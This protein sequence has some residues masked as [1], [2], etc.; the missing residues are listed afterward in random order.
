MS[1][2]V[3]YCLAR[4]LSSIAEFIFR[5]P[6]PTPALTKQ[7]FDLL[8]LAG[9]FSLPKMK[10]INFFKKFLF[11]KFLLYKE[12]QV[13]SKLFLAV[14]NCSLSIFRWKLDLLKSHTL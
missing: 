6:F 12:N 14:T 2:E 3:L 9:S 7:L 4:C 10:T 1:K 5:F 11:P 13:H 8:K